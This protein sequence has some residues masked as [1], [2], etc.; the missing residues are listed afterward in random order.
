M[1]KGGEVYIIANRFRSGIYVGVSADIVR[2]IHTHRERKDSW[3]VL[4]FNKTRLGCVERQAEIAPAITP[5]KLVK[6]WKRE[7]KFALI[8]ENRPDWRDL[9]EE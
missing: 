1:E 8:E 9:R 4:D 6:K 3:Y 2:R 7:R 5:K